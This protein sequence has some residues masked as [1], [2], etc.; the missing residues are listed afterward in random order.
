MSVGYGYYR[1]NIPPRDVPRRTQ[2]RSIQTIT[3]TGISD[4][5]E[6]VKRHLRIMHSDLDIV[7]T[8]KIDA[9]INWCELAIFRTCRPSATY[10]MTD[11]LWPTNP[12]YVPDASWYWFPPAANGLLYFYMPPLV[13]VDLVRYI[14]GTTRTTTFDA[15]AGV[16]TSTEVITLDDT[17]SWLAT[18]LQVTLDIDG[19]TVP[20][21]LTDGATYYV[22]AVS[23]TTVA[24]HTTLADALADT[25][26]VNITVAG[27]GTQILSTLEQKVAATSYHVVLD[28]KT[29]SFLQFDDTFTA[30]D[31]DDRPDAV[32]YDYTCGYGDRMS[33]PA[34]IKQAIKFYAAYLLDERE[35]D[36][37]AAERCLQLNSY[38]SYA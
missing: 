14:D 9:A 18:G 21:G 7:L 5:L 30:P 20:T 29:R 25:N 32:I 38:G 1:Y 19:G 33:I 34:T 2:Q 6:S 10:R 11:R 37:N 35:E 8:E 22:Q 36:Y 27:S 16:N 3:Q 24:L 4:T 26:R 28:T 31:L 23:T 15:N 13:S 12:N 17:P